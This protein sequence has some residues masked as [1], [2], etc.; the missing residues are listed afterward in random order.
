MT[1]AHF[2]YIPMMVIVGI[3]L[4]FILGSRAARDAFNLERKR[5]EERQKRKEERER[6][7]QAAAKPRQ[8]RE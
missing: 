6:E 4:G 3:V 1:A 2:I 5:E 7:R 8:K